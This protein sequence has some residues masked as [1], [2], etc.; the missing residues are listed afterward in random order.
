MHTFRGEACGKCLL[1]CFASGGEGRGRLPFSEPRGM[2]AMRVREEQDE[3]H[4]RRSVLQRAHDFIGEKWVGSENEVGLHIVKQ[5]VKLTANQ[6]CDYTIRQQRS[7]GRI[8]EW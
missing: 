8:Y 2:H 6:V 4:C 1:V 7:R 5:G 3:R